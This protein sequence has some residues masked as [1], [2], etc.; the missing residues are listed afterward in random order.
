MQ[1]ETTYILEPT[2]FH[3][4]R[5]AQDLTDQLEESLS[6]LSNVAANIK[7][8]VVEMFSEMVNNAAEHGMSDAG[9]HCH[10]RLMPHRRGLALDSVITD[11]GLGIRATL[12]RN[13]DLQVESDE[14]A[15]RLAVQELT[16]GTGNPTRGI[17]LWTAFLE[18]QK[19]GRKLQVHSG[20][21][22]AHGLRSRLGGILNR[23]R[24][25]RNHRPVHD[26]HLTSETQLHEK[27]ANLVSRSREQQA[28]P[29]CVAWFPAGVQKARRRPQVTKGQGSTTAALQRAQE[30]LRR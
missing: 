1:D 26:P 21:G 22:P 9:A 10:V 18:C 14:Q 6:E 24:T 30:C 3:S 28:T 19:P 4:M 16:S 17:G 5:E 15:L 23:P 27:I 29:W 20:T 7:P 25:P 12:E 13:P 11:R 8:Q 2:A